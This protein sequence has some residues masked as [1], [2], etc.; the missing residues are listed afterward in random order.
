MYLIIFSFGLSP[1]LH[2]HLDFFV[3]FFVFS[4]GG[5]IFSP[6]P[7]EVKVTFLLIIYSR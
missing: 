3:L 1:I 5:L 7:A 2:I 4:L 6:L